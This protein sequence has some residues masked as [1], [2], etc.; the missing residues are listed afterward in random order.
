MPLL[1]GG[2]L[3]FRQVAELTRRVLSSEV[4]LQLAIERWDLVLDFRISRSFIESDMSVID[5][6]TAS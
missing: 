4:E 2:V 3:A 1:G 5:V 6:K